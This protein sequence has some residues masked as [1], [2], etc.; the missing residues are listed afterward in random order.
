[1]HRFLPQH[2]RLTYIDADSTLIV[3]MPS[4]IHEA[5]LAALNTAL[6]FFFES[7]PFDHDAIIVDI[8]SNIEASDSLV[9][10]LR[11][12]FQN[13]SNIAAEIV[14]PGLAETA[15]SQN[16][17]ALE[18]KLVGA[19]EAN[20]ALLLVVAAIVFE[21]APYRSPKK[22]SDTARALL[23]DSSQQS[24]TDFIATTGVLPTL[25]SPVVVANHTWCS[26]SSVWFKVWVRGNDPI[27]IYTDDPALVADGVMFSFIS[28]FIVNTIPTASVSAGHYGPGACDDE[29]RS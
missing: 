11:I 5:P 29:E 10:D 6:T 16:R 23:Q 12:S 22:G 15:F 20:P 1:M 2:Y 13:M 19:V 25:D 8:L 26:V 3:E 9:P 28:K 27:D 4:A 21:N 18:N 14:I 24:A 17:H 7:I